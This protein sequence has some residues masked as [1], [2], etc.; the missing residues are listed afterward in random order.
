MERASPFS[1]AQHRAHTPRLPACPHTPPRAPR[2]HVSPFPQPYAHTRQGAFSAKD[3]RDAT[4]IGSTGLPTNAVYPSKDES[5]N[6]LDTEFGLSTYRDSQTLTIQEMPEAAPLGQ[7]PRS[8]DV[9][10]ENDLVDAVKPGDRVAVVGVYR[11]IAGGGS[12]TNGAFKTL[13]IA[14]SVRRTSRE[15]GN[16]SL[17][18]GDIRNIRAMASRSDIFNL[19]SRSL[20]PSIYGHKFIKQALALLLLGGVE[21]VLPNGTHLRGACGFGCG[22]GWGWWRWG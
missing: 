10:V 8:L 19:L 1:T 13:L 22:V 14:N 5:G 11:A 6:K 3:F 20:A 16:V 12:T 17:A 15:T 2:R 21:H 7:L 9:Y 18:A 4:D